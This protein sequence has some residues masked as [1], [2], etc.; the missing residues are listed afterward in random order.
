M[1]KNNRPRT[2][3]STSISWQK[4][5]LLAIDWHIKQLGHSDRSTYI[6]GVMEHL[7]GIREHPELLG[8]DYPFTRAVA[9][10][11]E[12]EDM[13]GI[14]LKAAEKSAKNGYEVFV[15]KGTTSLVRRPLS[16]LA[17]PTAK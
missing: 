15:E 17:K 6:N 2:T 14:L 4:N 13:R 1:G 10:P 11:W 3:A 7:Y 9:K 16:P 12:D 8:R 5:V